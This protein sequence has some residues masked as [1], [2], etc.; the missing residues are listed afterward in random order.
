MKIYSLNLSKHSFYVRVSLSHILLCI[1]RDM[2]C[3]TWDRLSQYTNKY[4]Q[5]KNNT[6]T[7]AGLKTLTAISSSWFV[8][9][10]GL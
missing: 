10:S 3:V 7:T 9:K 4:G 8:D 2:D 1:S 5:A 6:K